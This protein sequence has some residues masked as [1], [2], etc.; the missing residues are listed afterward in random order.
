MQCKKFS[1]DTQRPPS[2][3]TDPRFSYHLCKAAQSLGMFGT[4]SA[5]C[6]GKLTLNV[7]SD[8]EKAYD[9]V[10]PSLYAMIGLRVPPSMQCYSCRGCAVLTFLDILN[11]R[12]LY[13]RSLGQIFV[14]VLISVP[15]SLAGSGYDEG[16]QPTPK[17]GPSP[18]LA[19]SLILK[20]PRHQQG[21]RT[22]PAKEKK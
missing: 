18:P 15:Q 1:V 19:S 10:C 22:C 9:C 8:T 13:P 3:L 11:V 2:D 20:K 17:S 5:D 21:V 12:Y 14:L 4:N 7:Y 16:E 6:S